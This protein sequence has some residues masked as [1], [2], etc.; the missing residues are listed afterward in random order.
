[1]KKNLFYLF[2]LICS[3]SL[4]TACSDDDDAPDYSKVIESEIAGDYKGTLD[5]KLEGTTIASGLPKNITIS[6]AGNSTINLLLANFSLMGMDLGDIELKDCQ[7][8]QKDNSYSFTG[9]QSLNIEKYQLKADVKATG[10]IV[11]GTITVQLDIAAKLNGLSQN[12]QVTY[13]GTKMTGNES[14]EAKI[15]AFTFES[16]LVTERPVINEEDGTIVFKV[17]EDATAADLSAL[18]PVITVSEGAIVTPKSGEA[19]D[20]SNGNKIVYTVLSEDYSQMKTYTVFV[21]GTQKVREYSFDE[22]T[23]DLS[24]TDEK[25]Q[26]PIIGTDHNNPL[27]TSCNQA[28]MLIKTLGMLGGITYTGDY[29]V[30]PT[31]D[32]VS[33]KAI[34]MESVFTTGGA[35]FETPVPK[36]TAATA[37]LGT[38]NAMAAVTEGDPMLST[39]FGIM[40]PDK[41]LEVRG[42]FKYTAGTPFYN[43]EGVEVDKKDECAIS[44]VLY[45]IENEEETLHGGNIYTATNIVASAIFNSGDQQDYTPFSLKLAYHKEYD[46]T[47]KYKFAVILSASKDGAAYEAAVGSKLFVDNVS[48]ICE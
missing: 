48:I 4:F 7:L 40:F 38:F 36:V 47:K 39:K 34:L 20:F 44:A 24:Q 15:T 12:V 35:I 8:S 14:S 41:P 21:A 19:K 43:K 27:W 1:M 30:R 28:V 29:P 42:F 3:M 17:D 45:E 31:D 23:K 32:A 46:T 9:I 26:F 33:G 2:A 10:T 6:K 25:A 5:I 37:F 11:D 22:W 18:V 13:E 16:E